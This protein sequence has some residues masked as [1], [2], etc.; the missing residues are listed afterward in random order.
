M[1]TT[2]ASD[3]E[4][5]EPQKMPAQP[6]QQSLVTPTRRLADADV[7]AAVLAEM[8]G[9]VALLEE[10][11]KSLL[12]E[13]TDFGKIPGTKERSLWQPGAE[14]IRFMFD[15]SADTEII[16][17]HEDWAN[18]IFAYDARCIVYNA[19]GRMLTRA[20]STSS[21]EEEKYKSQQSERTVTFRNG[22]E[23][24]YPA[25]SAAEFR[26]VCMMM[27]QKR[28]F[29]YGIRRVGAA[30][31]FFSQDDDL[32]IERED[33]QDRRRPAKDATKGATPR[34]QKP[35]QINPEYGPCPAH[36]GWGWTLSAK[37]RDAG[38]GASHIVSD[39]VFCEYD[40]MR[41]E[42][43]ARVSP[44]VKARFGTGAAASHKFE[45]WLALMPELD[46]ALPHAM[47]FL[48]YRPCDWQLLGDYLDALTK[49]EEAAEEDETDGTDTDTDGTDASGQA[50]AGGEAAGE[51][52]GAVLGD[53]SGT[54]SRT[55]ESAG[56]VKQH[57]PVHSAGRMPEGQ[58]RLEENQPARS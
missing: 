37:A 13:G 20:E 22:D 38:H 9:Q 8:R 18:G 39:G 35:K 46:A 49:A 7:R 41:K 19:A 17:S 5:Y 57:S 16:R 29:V 48:A 11:T 53:S 27:A 58:A 42:W 34:A 25:K 6:Q 31:S 40:T 23:K 45:A 54:G 36:E 33:W 55:A 28:A 43:Q 51:R 50:G 4:V 24:T 10:A 26:Q 2:G 32:A 21:T 14:K 44:V 52:P 15:L 56:A 1:A 30:S 3:V 47:D 12:K